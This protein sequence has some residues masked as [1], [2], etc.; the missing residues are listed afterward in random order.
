M[1]GDQLLSAIAQRLRVCLRVSDT[2]ARLGGDEFAIL[3]EDV[4]NKDDAIYV[5]ERIGHELK[6]P[7]SLGGHEVFAAASVGILL[8]TKDYDRPEELLRDADTA[9]YRAKAQGKG[10]YEVFDI[11]MRD[12]AIA[13]LHLENDLRRAV[14]NQEFQLHY[15]P[16]VSLKDQKIIGFE[17]LV[18]W[19]HPQRGLI[20]PME[21]IPI[22]EDTGLIIPLGWWVLKEA[23]LQMRAWQLQFVVEPPLTINVNLS[24]K[25]FTQVN[26]IEQINQILTETGLDAHSL[27]LEITESCIVEN[28]QSA[29][30]M[31]S[32]LQEMGIQV[33]IDDFGTGYSSLAYLHRFPVNTLKI[34][35]SFINGLGGDGHEI[36]RAIVNLAWNLGME[37]VAEGVETDQ[38]ITQ[39]NGLKSNSGQEY[40]GQGY[41]FSKPLN[42][43]AATALMSIGLSCANNK[44]LG[45]MTTY[46]D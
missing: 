24:G 35:R 30:L 25:Q 42:S 15:Q 16:I 28:M 39:L 12:R 46:K 14:E 32:K 26:L 11:G 33:A 34:D 17:A 29:A 40:L 9:M 22:E 37:V 45:E 13:L 10:C 3:L 21:F 2:F 27:K 18:R 31:L 43:D 19:H 41:L 23:C 6:L 1:V 5:A 36:V 8:G 4:Q 38:Q 44:K 7:F 20:A